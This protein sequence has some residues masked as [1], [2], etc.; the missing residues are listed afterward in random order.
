M[1]YYRKMLISLEQEKI[2][3][4]EHINI[5]KNKR[6]ISNDLHLKQCL[7]EKW[8]DYVCANDELTDQKKCLNDIE[9]EILKIQ[10]ELSLT[11]KQ[12]EPSAS[13]LKNK[14]ECDLQKHEE[15]LENKLHVV[16]FIIKILIVN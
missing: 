7:I 6:K 3:L 16:R 8:N 5:A 1:K 9:K 15:L 11:F 13:K 14:V 2:N 4:V 10:N 12:R